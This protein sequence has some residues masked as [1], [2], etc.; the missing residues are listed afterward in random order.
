MKVNASLNLLCC[1]VF[2]P[3]IIGA[4]VVDPPTIKLSVQVPAVAPTVG[5]PPI[6]KETKSNLKLFRLR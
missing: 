1:P 5:G 2:T 6:V 4:T 3:Q